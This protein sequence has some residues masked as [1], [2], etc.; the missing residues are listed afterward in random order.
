MFYL[1]K[2]ERKFKAFDTGL[3]DIR[4]IAEAADGAL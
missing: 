2:G 3:G 1:P 4:K